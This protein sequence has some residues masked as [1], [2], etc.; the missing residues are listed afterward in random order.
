[1]RTQEGQDVLEV[2][3]GARPGADRRRIERAAA[4]GEKDEARETAADL[5]AARAD[6]LVR[7]PITREVKDRAQQERR[8]PRPT[9]GTGRGAR[10]HVKGDDHGCR[11]SRRVR[12]TR[13]DPTPRAWRFRRQEC[14]LALGVGGKPRFFSRASMALESL[15]R[16]CQSPTAERA[17]ASS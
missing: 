13:A 7:Q 3:R 5:E 9:R 8:D 11:P 2:G 17:A 10:R 12:E 15:S 4:C 1:M 14:Y 6:V 16:F